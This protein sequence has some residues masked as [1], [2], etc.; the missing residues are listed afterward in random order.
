MSRVIFL[1]LLLCGTAHAQMAGGIMDSQRQGTA[2]I[3]GGS[4]TG[5]TDLAVTDGG[6]GASTARAAA[7]NLGVPY[8][9][10]QSAVAVSAPA[11]TSEDTLYTCT[12]PANAIGPNGSLRVSLTWT[13]AGA[14]GNN[15]MRARF[16]GGAGTVFMG[17]VLGGTYNGFNQVALLS[18]RNA[19]NSQISSQDNNSDSY[20]SSTGVTNATSAVDTTAS[21]T[22]VITCQ[23]ASAG[24]T[25]TLLRV[26]IELLYGAGF[27]LDRFMPESLRDA[28]A[29]NDARYGYQEAA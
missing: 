7:A 26:L 15:T 17:R 1:L 3:T 24:D 4:I 14:G 29:A 2:A 8:V 5:I 12:V 22:V 25:C 18:N 13:R 21:T 23:K 20:V 27:S 10:C 16:S 28:V 11:D 6:T 19:T 9:L